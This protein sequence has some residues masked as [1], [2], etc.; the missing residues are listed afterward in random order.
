MFP[1]HFGYVVCAA[2]VCYAACVFYVVDALYVVC[3]VYA[4]SAVPT[5]PSAD[6]GCKGV[7]RIRSDSSDNRYQDVT[8]TSWLVGDAY[9]ATPAPGGTNFVKR[10]PEPVQRR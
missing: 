3:V 8:G 9:T 10:H 5:V 1:F 6:A 7:R 2:Y 4:I